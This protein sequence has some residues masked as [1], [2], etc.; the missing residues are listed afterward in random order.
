MPEIST[1]R[2][3]ATEA[4]IMDFVMNRMALGVYDALQSRRPKVEVGSFQIELLEIDEAAGIAHAAGPVTLRTPQGDVENHLRVSLEIRFDGDACLI[5]Q[6][7]IVRASY[8]V[9]TDSANGACKE[10]AALANA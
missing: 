7:G 3:A 8:I 2:E 4:A 5:R 1:A 6:D 10:T 9:E